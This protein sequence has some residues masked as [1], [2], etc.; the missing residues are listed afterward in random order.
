MVE[1]A[2]NVAAQGSLSSTLTALS[3][4]ARKPAP[5]V[6]SPRCLPGIRRRPVGS[7]TV[8]SD[9]TWTAL[10]EVIA[11]PN[12]ANASDLATVAGDERATTNS[13]V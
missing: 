4:P 10:R 11:A 7:I 1:A 3:R 5:R 12:W 9:I 8:E 2:L 13:T 6:R